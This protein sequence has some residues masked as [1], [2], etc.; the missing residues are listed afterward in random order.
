MPVPS[1]R[2]AAAYT[3]ARMHRGGCEMPPRSMGQV[4]SSQLVSCLM[5]APTT[6]PRSGP[7]VLRGRAGRQ[8]A[9]CTVNECPLVRRSCC[10]MD[11]AE[12]NPLAHRRSW[13]AHASPPQPAC[14]AHMRRRLLAQRSRRRALDRC[15]VHVHVVFVVR[16]C[17]R[18]ATTAGADV[19]KE[20]KGLSF[21][22]RASPK[23]RVH[24]MQSLLSGTAR[25]T[26]PLNP[27]P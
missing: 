27:K 5:L 15:V 1:C 23:L 11:K 25:A 14:L 18:H 24:A 12:V 4:T 20:T 7:A 22:N 21:W 2:A 17:A 8:R 19:A 16:H 6:A 9:Y 13:L 10:S 3:Y 26:P